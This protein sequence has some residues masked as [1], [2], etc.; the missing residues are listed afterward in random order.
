MTKTTFAWT[1][2]AAV[3]ALG[4]CSHETQPRM[5]ETTPT[6][7]QFESEQPAQ[8][9]TAQEEAPRALLPEGARL[10]AQLDQPLGINSATPGQ[11]FSATVAQP[12]LDEAG[13]VA[14]PFGAKVFGHVASVQVGA[15][16]Q[17]A[18][19]ALVVDSVSAHDLSRPL[20]ARIVATDVDAPRHGINQAFL[21]ARSGENALG[22]VVG[23][24]C[25][26]QPVAGG[27]QASLISLGM[28]GA[29]NALPQGTAIVLELDEAVP[30]S[31]SLQPQGD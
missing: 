25:C 18:V 29:V 6:Y 20:R 28:P 8:Q 16:D 27:P 26:R 12:A 13:N 15:P 5:V 23:G 30:S 11:R 9:P 24:G 21:A 31:P 3:A 19:I 17:P 14:I 7:G 4:G 2:V 10:V 1:A 22:A